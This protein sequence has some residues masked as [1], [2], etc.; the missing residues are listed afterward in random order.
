MRFKYSINNIKKHKVLSTILIIQIVL[1]LF[2]SYFMIY[3]TNVLNKEIEKVDTVL[4]SGNIFSIT[5]N[6]DYYEYLKDYN[7]EKIFN[8]IKNI[9]DVKIISILD[10]GITLEGF[11]PDIFTDMTVYSPTSNSIYIDGVSVNKDVIDTFNIQ[12]LSGRY[13][14][15]EEYI[16]TDTTIL[17]ILIGYDFKDN[18]KIGDLIN[19]DS[20]GI[21]KLEVIGIL[22]KGTELP[23]HVGK[24]LDYKH[25]IINMD[26][27][28][29]TTKRYWTQDDVYDF[30]ITDSYFYINP[31]NLNETKNKIKTIFNN[32]G[33]EVNISSEKI[34]IELT[35]RDLKEKQEMFFFTTIMII[36][37]TALT[38]IFTFLNSLNMRKQ[39]FGTYL[40]CG[41]K[42]QDLSR[43]IV[44][45]LFIINSI[46]LLMFTIITLLIFGNI[47]FTI[48]ITMIIFCILYVLTLTIIPLLKLNKFSIRDLTKGDE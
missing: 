14:T 26:N 2:S 44:Y 39:E 31:D 28:I 38:I 34:G 36:T 35:I 40:L 3:S 41:A 13:F 5:S 27:K 20:N 15:I 7:S 10:I 45:E 43:I 37:F 19:Y 48:L 30:T 22:E 12:L 46:S 18:F 8:Q 32:E 47:S 21:N 1:G 4:N 24:S 17:P 33:I 29:L 16:E 9:D 23:Q 42:K 11:S 6:W 25:K